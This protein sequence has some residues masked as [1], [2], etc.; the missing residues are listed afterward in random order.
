MLSPT[1]F[2]VP[3][4]SISRSM[5][6]VAR[7]DATDA[8]RCSAKTGEGVIDVIEAMIA[9]VPPPKGDRTAPRQSRGGAHRW[10]GAAR[11]A[12][13]WACADV[14]GGVRHGQRE[15]PRARR[16]VGAAARDRVLTRYSWA[17]QLAPLRDLVA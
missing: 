16:E 12:G 17:A 9:R 6:L 8:V 7:V 11:H 3:T 15:E 5:S 10:G 4:K 2:G 13:H 14:L 1:R